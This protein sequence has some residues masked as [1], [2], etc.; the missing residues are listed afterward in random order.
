MSAGVRPLE[1][2]WLPD[3]PVGDTVLRGFVQNQIELNETI[4]R[5]RDGRVDQTADVS[6]VETGPVT[7]FLNQAV[8]RRNLAGADDPVLGHVEAFYRHA[9]VLLSIWPTPDL[10]R[11]GWRLVGHPVFVVRAPAAVPSVPGDVA[12]RP[13]TSVADLRAFEQVVLDGYPMPPATD[14]GPT[15]AP[16]LLGSALRL[17]VAH[18]DGGP[19]ATGGSHVAHGVVNLCMAATLPAARRRGAW[20]ALVHARVADDPAQPAVAFTS[21]DSRPGFQ[22]LGFLPVTRFT[23]WTRSG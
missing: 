7:A 23:L 13:V 19:V 3:T 4:A 2:G 15:F 18:L 6:L 9:C 12:V 20:A 21:D 16:P 14:G 11:R 1:T 8:L 17:R 22:R 10:S 5:A